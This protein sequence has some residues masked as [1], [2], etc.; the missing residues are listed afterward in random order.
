MCNFLVFWLREVTFLTLVLTYIFH[1]SLKISNYPFLEL[2]ATLHFFINYSNRRPYTKIFQ[3]NFSSNSDRS[4]YDLRYIWT[5]LLFWGNFPLNSF[6][7]KTNTAVLWPSFKV[8]L[9]QMTCEGSVPFCIIMA[10]KTSPPQKTFL[11]LLAHQCHS[12]HSGNGRNELCPHYFTS[13]M[14][15]ICKVFI[16]FSKLFWS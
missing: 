11:G 14:S 1:H 9:Y 12:F 15:K 8:L 5:M 2:S 4:P 6:C 7:N 10:W 16:K 3:T 13:V